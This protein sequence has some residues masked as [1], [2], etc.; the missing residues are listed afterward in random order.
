MKHR[1][2]ITKIYFWKPE[3]KITFH[4]KFG[5]NIFQSFHV[6]IPRP[7]PSVFPPIPTIFK[8]G[9]FIVQRLI[10]SQIK[11]IFSIISNVI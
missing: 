11:Y 5:A 4:F 8:S 6:G 9:Y 1:H 7:S 3:K 2:N 10:V